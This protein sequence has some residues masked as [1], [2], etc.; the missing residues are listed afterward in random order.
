MII[1]R[2]DICNKELKSVNQITE[3]PQPQQFEGVKDVCHTC[4]AKISVHKA[5][6]TKKVEALIDK[7]V[8]NYVRQLMYETN[9]EN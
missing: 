8:K 6:I 3:L 1:I 5:V 4:L 9:L 7:T 2:C